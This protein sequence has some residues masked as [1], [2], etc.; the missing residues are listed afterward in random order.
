MKPNFFTNL[1]LKNKIKKSIKKKVKQNDPSQ[2]KF[3]C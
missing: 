2:F 3:T 1:V